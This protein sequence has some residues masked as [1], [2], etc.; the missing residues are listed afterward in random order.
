MVI[1]CCGG[2]LRK[3][4]ATRLRG[5]GSTFYKRFVLGRRLG[6]LCCLT[7]AV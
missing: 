2:G 6:F 1:G 5:G 4:C 3:H 7:L